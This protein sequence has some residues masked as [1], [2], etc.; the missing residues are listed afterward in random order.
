[1]T[2]LSCFVHFFY[3]FQLSLCLYLITSQVI[4]I[5]IA[6]G[7]FWFNIGLMLP[8]IIVLWLPFIITHIIWRYSCLTGSF[9][10][11]VIPPIALLFFRSKF[12]SKTIKT[13]HAHILAQD[14]RTLDFVGAKYLLRFK[15]VCEIYVNLN[16]SLRIWRTMNEVTMEGTTFFLLFWKIQNKP[17]NLKYSPKLP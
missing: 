3:S 2:Q 17:F 12:I 4:N 1:M 10:L 14:L 7:S 11:H 15:G 9:I 6:R 5:S 16:S 8:Y 13:D